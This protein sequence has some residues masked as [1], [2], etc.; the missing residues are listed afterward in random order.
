MEEAARRSGRIDGEHVLDIAEHQQI[1]SAWESGVVLAVVR[2]QELISVRGKR[3]KLTGVVSGWRGKW[4]NVLDCSW[5]PAEL[6][7]SDK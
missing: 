2:F 7:E 6:S 3:S 1:L 5:P 4:G